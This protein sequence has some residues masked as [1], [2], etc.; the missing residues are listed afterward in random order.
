MKS[1]SK[2]RHDFPMRGQIQ[3]GYPQVCRGLLRSV[4]DNASYQIKSADAPLIEA[5][6]LTVMD[7]R[8][9]EDYARAYRGRR[10]RALW[11]DMHKQFEQFKGRKVRWYAIPARPPGRP[12]HARPRLR[13]DIAGV[14]HERERM[15]RLCQDRRQPLLSD[16]TESAVKWDELFAKI[17]AGE[18]FH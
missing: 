2:P 6:D 4:T 9:A 12:Y 15:D 13:R 17:D 11:R 3:Q 16:F 5:G 18:A 10:Q 8:R 14:R 7:I 1:M